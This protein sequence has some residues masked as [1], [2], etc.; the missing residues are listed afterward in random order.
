[1]AKQK[2]APKLNLNVQKYYIKPQITSNKPRFETAYLCK[3]V[4]NLLKQ[5]VALNVTFLGIHYLFKKCIDLA[6][7]A[8]WAKNS[9]SGHPDF[10]PG[11][12]WQLRN[13][14]HRCL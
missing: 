10:Q 1:M 5:K 13:I 4:K 12:Y 2:N 11:Y 3:N 9:Q 14:L 7:A 6:K 8:Q